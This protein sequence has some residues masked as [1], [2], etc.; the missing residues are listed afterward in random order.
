MTEKEWLDCTGPMLDFVRG[1]ASERKSRL[2]ACACCRRV[3]KQLWSGSVGH[4][5]VLTAERYADGKASAEELSNCQR[6]VQEQLELYPGEPVYDA[7]YWVCGRDIQEVIEGSA[8]YAANNSTLE[9]EQDSEDFD[10][11][12]E[13]RRDEELAVQ[14]SFLHDL[15]GPLLFR[16]VDL[17]PSWLTW[18]D[19]TVRRIAQAIYDERGFDRL[20]ILADALE[21]AGCQDT[22][23]LTHCR[24]P[25][26]HVRGCFVVDLLLEKE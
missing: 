6:L 18:N 25:G 16:S 20:P 13:R 19:G 22:E 26:P 12:C 5:G 21:D 7:S 9:V 15:F 11:R 4:E 17:D 1:K 24:G 14:A 8:G 2:F 3:W 23:I 10:A